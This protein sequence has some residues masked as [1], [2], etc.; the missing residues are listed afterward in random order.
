MNI[1]K[2]FITMCAAVICLGGLTANAQDDPSPYTKPDG[3][4]IT[5]SGTVAA[6]TDTSF[7]LDYGKGIVTVEMDDWD[8][9]AE[10]N[11]IIEGDKVTVYGRVDDDLYEL[12]SI[13][14]SSVY[15]ENLNTYFYASAA[16]EEGTIISDA[17]LVLSWVSVTGEVTEID[18]REFTVRMGP[19]STMTVD[20]AAMLYNPLD[21]IGY[22]QIEVG[23]RVRASGEID[24]GFFDGRELEAASVVTL[25]QD[26]GKAGTMNE[27]K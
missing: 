17:P 12:T 16:D 14:A 15:V 13:E 9:Y 4:W 21:D 10:G 8:W 3:S 18:G 23:D 22:Q 19:E 26:V 20:T 7:T 11:K 25:Q 6:A 27:E 24:V 5:L 1:G 2:T